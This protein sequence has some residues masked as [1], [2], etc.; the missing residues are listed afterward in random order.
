MNIP[1]DLRDQFA[2]AAT[3]ADIQHHMLTGYVWNR[4]RAR[5]AFADAMLDAR[6]TQEQ[7]DAERNERGEAPPDDGIP[8]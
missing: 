8:F 3:E 2:L 4:E 7:R 6:K 5:Y 1:M